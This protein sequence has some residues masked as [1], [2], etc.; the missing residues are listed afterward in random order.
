M[1]ELSLSRANHEILHG[2]K[3]AMGHPETT[4]GWGTPAGKLRAA[5][6]AELIAEGARLGPSQRSLEVGCG[7][8]LF[9][10]L[11]AASGAEIFAVDISSELLDLARG[12]G[13]PTTQ[14]HFLERRFEDCDVDGPFDSVVGSS[15]L[16]HLDVNV[17]LRRIYELLRPG[18]AISFAEPN[19]LNPQVA[20]MKNVPLV[21]A[22]LGDSPDERAFVRWTLQRQLMDAGFREVEVRPFDWLHPYTPAAWIRIVRGIGGRLEDLPIVREFAGSLYIRAIRPA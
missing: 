14:V 6:R 12:R 1:S 4:W 21:K 17:S 20:V 10:E 16:H 3:L 9:T 22:W 19:M 11:L 2:K 7:T 8:G 5:R 18:G 13:L 15:I